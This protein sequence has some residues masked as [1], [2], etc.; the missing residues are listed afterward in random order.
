MNSYF[1]FCIESFDGDLKISTFFNAIEKM[2]FFLIFHV[3]FLLLFRVVLCVW[4]KG[5]VINFLEFG[6]MK[7]IGIDEQ[8]VKEK[9]FDGVLLLEEFIHL[10]SVLLAQKT[11]GD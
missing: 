7:S 10:D 4:Q 6:L 1:C 3:L 5:K 8:I 9:I 11:C 2:W